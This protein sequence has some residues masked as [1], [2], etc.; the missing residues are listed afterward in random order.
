MD[1]SNVITRDEHQRAIDEIT[2]QLTQMEGGQ[3]SMNDA[4]QTLLDK[5]ENSP[6]AKRA[7]I[8]APDSE[9]DK[10]EV[11][12]FGDFLVAVRRGNHKRLASVYKSVNQKDMSST[13][14]G[15]GGY[16]VPTDYSTALLQVMEEQNAISSRCFNQ[17]VNGRSGDFPLLDRFITPTAGSG[18]T[19]QSGGLTPGTVQEGGAYGEDEPT[20]EML[21]YQVKKI[22][23]V[24]DVPDELLDD[25]G[26]AIEALLTRLFAIATD[27]IVERH[28]LRGSGGSEWL[29]ILN[30]AAAIGVTPASNNTFGEA[31]ALGMLSRFKP[32]PAGNPVWIMHRGVIPDFAGFTSNGS[33]LVEWRQQVPSA[34]LGYPII[35]SEH[36]P[37]D[38]NAGNVI[39]ADLS[40][41]IIFNRRQLTVAFS[42][43][44][45]FE[46]DLVTW[47]YS[48]RADGMPWLKSAITLPDPQ[49]S[50]TVSPFVYHND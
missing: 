6:A 21:S 3:K 46:N 44:A 32:M 45:K 43:H 14:G 11:K 35:Y 9:E 48:I 13:T 7:G 5:L 20:F 4:I 17:P 22:G 42:E 39:L 50:Y 27:S 23:E 47:K 49:G 41:Y 12:S 40:A 36:A 26:I 29:G 15:A 38:D 33:D 25:S 2:A 16:L 28:I 31:D 30:S 37:Q 1:E 18:H 10:P 19:P 8:V 34:L 24:V